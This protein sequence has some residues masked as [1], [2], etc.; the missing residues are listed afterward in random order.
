MGKTFA[1]IGSEIVDAYVSR[2][3]EDEGL[4][5]VEELEDAAIVITYCMHAGALEDAYFD[6]DGIIKRAKPGTLLIDLSPSTPAF[7]REIAA[8]ATVSDLVPVEAPIAVADIFSPD[9]FSTP[10]HATCFV[11]GEQADVEA[12]LPYV[13]AFADTVVTV[14]TCGSGQLAKAAHTLQ[15]VAQMMAAIEA[16][17]LYEAVRDSGNSVDRYDGDTSAVTFVERAA[18]DAID[19]KRFDGAF[20]VEMLLGDVVAAMTAADDV[21]LILPQLESA[22]H[23]LEVLAVIGG[24]DKS[25]AA[26]ALLYRDEEA[27][28]AEGLD[29]SR[30]AVF[31]DHVHEHAHE[32][33]DDYD[34]DY[35]FDTYDYDDTTGYGGFGGYSDN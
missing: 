20:T 33:D 35:G 12:A 11:A 32:H 34:D 5:R 26:L 19:K 27:G 7:A 18:K 29:W 24:A 1:F 6:T 23:L 17:A 21:D 14:G 30:A 9:A 8:V 10:A 16:D 25:P 28:T 2:C 3:L 31:H 15:E 13:R 4:K 22:M